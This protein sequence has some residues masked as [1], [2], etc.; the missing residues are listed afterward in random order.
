MDWFDNL[1]KRF[2]EPL[3]A[4]EGFAV[5]ME[6]NFT[7]RATQALALAREE[8]CRL[9]HHFLGTEHVL[10]G[11]IKLGQGVAV[12]VLMKFG[13]DLETVRGEVERQVGM[14]PEQ[15]P[16]LAIP[17][18]PRV[19]KVIALAQKEAK[20]LHH[21]YVGTEHLLLGLM[22]ECDGVA[23]KVL[24]Q[25][26]V[27][28]TLARKHIL[29]ELDPN[30]DP[31]QE[32]AKETSAE[33]LETSARSSSEA[34]TAEHAAIDT[35]KRYDVYCMEANQITIHRNVL[36]KRMKH[37][38]KAHQYDSLSYFV[39]LEQPGGRTCFVARSSVIRFCEAEKD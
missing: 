34:D 18:T 30:F 3:P 25:L 14:G 38:F 11:L 21:T 28:I 16:N 4:A 13:L 9:N 20:Q 19:K 29:E 26:G 10:L 39:E 7:P 22:R 1:K 15:K 35:S 37:L 12:N 32:M 23:A 2:T 6:G 36:F 5:P 8:A 24:H 31:N 33:P 17:Y 27:D